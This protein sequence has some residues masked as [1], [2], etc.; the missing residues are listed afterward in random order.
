MDVNQAH[1][2]AVNENGLKMDLDD[3][4]HR[5]DVP[6][7]RP[8]EYDNTPDIVLPFTKVFH[9]DAALTS[10]A[11]R[12]GEAVVFSLQSGIGNAE[13]IAAHVPQDRIVLGM[14]LTPAEFVGPGRVASHGSATTQFGAKHP[15]ANIDLDAIQRALV[16][17]GIDAK[18][19]PTIQTAIWEKA[20]FNCVMNALCALTNATP[21]SIGTNDVAPKLLLS[22]RQWPKLDISLGYRPRSVRH[23][24]S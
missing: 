7:L 13:R 10:I 14:T 6:A 23:W 19:S 3:G 22:M 5:I 9:T 21:G 18:I 12:L 2:D 17:G 24:R 8:E 16:A 11:A 20:V 15:G 1:L 4:A